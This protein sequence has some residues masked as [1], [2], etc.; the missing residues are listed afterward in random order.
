MS[1]LIW[2]G[3]YE[4]DILYSK[5]L[6]VASITYYGSNKYMNYSFYPTYTTLQRL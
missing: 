5:N 4:S 1:Q 2:I 6:F 3:R